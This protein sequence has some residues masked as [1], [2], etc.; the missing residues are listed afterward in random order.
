MTLIHKLSATA[1]AGVT[2]FL[3]EVLSGSPFDLK[4]TC[5]DGRGP[6]SHTLPFHPPKPSEVVFLHVAGP[7]HDAHAQ[8][9]ADVAFHVEG[10]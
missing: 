6:M 1:S 2:S 8:K 10:V 4:P 7:A 5:V 9:I 3:E